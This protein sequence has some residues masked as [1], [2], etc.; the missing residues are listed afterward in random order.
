MANSH[1]HSKSPRADGAPE[2]RKGWF[3]G[4][5]VAT[6]I[7]VG[8]GVAV[9]AT[10]GTSGGSPSPSPARDVTLSSHAEFAVASITPANGTTQ[11]PS[12]ATISVSFTTP[13]SAQSPTPSLSPAIAGTWQVATPES[14]EFVP[15]APLVPSSTETVTVPGGASGVVSV[16]GKK[17]PRTTQSQFTVAAGSTLRVQQLLAQLGYLPVSF[18]PAG[19]VSSPQEE[20]EPQQGTFAWKFTEPASLVSL[21]TVGTTNTI[22]SGAIMAFESQH[23][24]D[25]DG[26]AGPQVWQQLLAAASSGSMDPAPYNYVYVSENLPETA[27]VYSNGNQVYST[28]ANTGVAGASTALG[29]FPVYERFKVTTMSGTN[30]DGSHYV[31]PGIPWVSYFNGGDALHGFNRASYGF[32]QSDGCVEMPPANAAVVWPLTPI[33]T[34]VTVS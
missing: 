21:W 31:D 7:V 14:F 32:P 11:I 25:T 29:T 28:L 15:S 1:A 33:G 30:P 4:I 20:A 26:I 17:L 6:V 24:M 9:V 5:V 16:A 13:L 18:T 34:L 19:P 8:V 12:D 27:T 23:N 22:T 3:L 2:G 10:R